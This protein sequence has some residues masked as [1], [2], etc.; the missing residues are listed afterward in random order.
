MMINRVLRLV[1]SYHDMDLSEASKRTGFSKS[2]ISGLERGH[3]KATLTVL[4]KY[5][6]AFDIPVSS[7]ML[8]S[9]GIESNKLAENVRLFATDKAVKMLE[10]IEMI[11]ADKEKNHVE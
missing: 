8:F 9:E 5:S 1:R 10:W 6:A 4:E 2:Y 11:N 3:K 7:L